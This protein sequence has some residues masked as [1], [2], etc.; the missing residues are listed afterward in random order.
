MDASPAQTSSARHPRGSSTHVRDRLTK[1]ERSEDL[2][3]LRGAVAPV[4]M[5]ARSK[6]VRGSTAEVVVA[7]G[8]A[9]EGNDA[10]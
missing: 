4:N 1:V 2:A 3:P 10:S 6:E 5:V 9:T 7:A 8:A